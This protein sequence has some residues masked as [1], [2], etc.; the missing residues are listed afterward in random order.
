MHV[1]IHIS[2]KYTLSHN[3]QLFR[4]PSSVCT[5]SSS[6]PPTSH[7]RPNTTGCTHTSAVLVEDQPPTQS[8]VSRRREPL[9]RDGKFNL[10]IIFIEYF[11]TAS[12]FWQLRKIPSYQAVIRSE[13]V[14]SSLSFFYAGFELHYTLWR[15]FAEKFY[16]QTYSELYFRVELFS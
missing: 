3:W 12:Y 2:P 5:V 13:E 14:F 9:N 8:Q 10:A 16:Q 7:F 15:G 11:H 4:F 1:D 6:P